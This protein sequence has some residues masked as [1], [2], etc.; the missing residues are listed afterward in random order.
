MRNHFRQALLNV[1]NQ[2]DTDI[3]PYPIEN[4]TFFDEQEATLDLLERY[5]A[6]FSDFMVR[7]PP[8]H[9][10][11]LAPIGYTGFR[12]ATQ[13]DP[14]WNLYFLGCVLSIAESI[15]RV[16]I[17]VEAQKIFSY[18]YAP[19]QESGRLFDTGIGWRQ[20][21]DRSSQLATDYPYVVTCDISEFYP[22]VGHH[23]LDN[24][25]RQ[26][27][28]E[29][30]IPGRIVEFLKQFSGTRSFGLPIGGPAARLLSELL[31]NQV[32][33]LLNGARMEFVR[34]A[35]DFHL[36]SNSREDAYASLVFLTE[37]LFDNQGLSLQKSKTR[38]MS[39]A[40][41]LA[42][43][44]LRFA[45]IE[46]EEAPG[47]G[48][49]AQRQAQQFMRFSL[50]FDP[51]SPTA[52]ED[53][54]ALK[55]ELSKFDVI[56]MLASELNKSQIHTSLSR[57]VIQTIRFLDEPERD[58]ALV[59]IVNNHDLLFP[60]YSNVLLAV[61]ELFD[62]LNQPSKDE[63]QA[64]LRELIEGESHVFRVDMHLAYAIRVLSN[65][66]TPE[67]E[68]LL[69][70]LYANRSSA[71]VRREIIIVMAHWRVWYWLSDLRVHYRELSNPE[72]RA[73]IIASYVL[74]EEGTHWRQHLRNEFSP[75]EL[76]VRDW[77]ASQKQRFGDW[78]V[79]V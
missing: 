63:I 32:D 14:I 37:K 42:T 10:N 51:Y 41:F 58:E 72:K 60:V 61:H 40:E 18:R 17:P 52:H 75:F 24:A 70:R 4:R 8:A 55:N 64:K 48:G 7:F 39:S 23:R 57:K 20:F 66:H 30:G 27:N 67:N 26:L 74:Q 12:W 19:D 62:E 3:F 43:S 49:R 38:I 65:Q 71:M 34:F 29:N 44:P 15:E 47:D 16:R 9:I 59:S 77:A 13:L 25:L 2:G 69:Q 78:R 5:H 28:L 6:S 68:G 46:D 76:L 54:E 1:A 56:G 53:Y 50:R 11:S 33:R 21:M 45:P 73:F 36:F 35:D 22:R 31:L 79:P